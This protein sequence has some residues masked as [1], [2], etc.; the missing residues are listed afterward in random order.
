MRRIDVELQ[1]VI[2]SQKSNI[3]L[4]TLYLWEI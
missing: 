1:V 4:Q 3:N 2:E